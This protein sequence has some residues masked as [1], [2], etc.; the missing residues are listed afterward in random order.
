MIIVQDDF[1]SINYV[2]EDKLFAKNRSMII[3]ICDFAGFKPRFL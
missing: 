3:N 2:Y 1:A